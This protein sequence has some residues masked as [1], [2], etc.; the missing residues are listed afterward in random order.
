M[1]ERKQCEF[2]LIR[3]VPDPVKNEFVN[4]GILLRAAAGGQSAVRF[5]KD[6]SRV[7]CIDPDADTEM[8]EAL[9]IEVAR[10]LDGQD[11]G[12]AGPVHAK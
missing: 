6:W 2:Q 10:R 7:R 5:T 12:S 9:E 8:L 4:I 1:P 3:Y 11:R